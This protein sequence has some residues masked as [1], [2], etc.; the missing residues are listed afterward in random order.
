MVVLI[1]IS[2]IISDIETLFVC[3]LA[4]GVSCL[5]TCLFRPSDHFFDGK[6]I[7]F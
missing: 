6:L 2:L 5:E 3:V 4:I 1:C 7:T